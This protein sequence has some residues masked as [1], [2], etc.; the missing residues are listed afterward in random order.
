MLAGNKSKEQTPCEAS[1]ND[2]D[3]A[4][5]ACYEEVE[6][7]CEYRAGTLELTAD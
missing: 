5:K 4:R 7:D 1:L 3:A 2:A 6:D